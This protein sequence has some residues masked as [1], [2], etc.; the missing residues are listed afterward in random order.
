MVQLLLINCLTLPHDTLLKVVLCS[1]NIFSYT[2]VLITNIQ[3]THSPSKKGSPN[4]QLIG[5]R[6]FQEEKLR[7]NCP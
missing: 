6:K 1:K 5:Y 3:P 4:K 2:P 7:A